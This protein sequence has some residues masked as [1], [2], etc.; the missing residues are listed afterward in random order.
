MLGQYMHSIGYGA[1]E[2]DSGYG[3]AF[4]GLGGLGQT[5]PAN[6]LF[7][8]VK[9][10]QGEFKGAMLSR[11]FQIVKE[12]NNYFIVPKGADVIS[13]L[14]QGATGNA[15][16]GLAVGALTNVAGQISGVRVM[17]PDPK[18]PF[19][20]QTDL[21]TIVYEPAGM[22]MLLIAGIAIAVGIVLMFMLKR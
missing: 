11:A 17:L 15:L 3:F 21:G 19:S 4:N 7:E 2:S 14:T 6:F 1:Y 13:G 12:G 22:N 5:G 9:I 18:Q 10:E 8:P 16:V 20:S